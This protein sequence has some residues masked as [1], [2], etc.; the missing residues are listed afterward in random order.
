MRELARLLVADPK[1]SHTMVD[2]HLLVLAP[3]CDGLG[4]EFAPRGPVSSRADALCSIT[5]EALRRIGASPDCPPDCAPDPSD[6]V[7]A[8]LVER[9]RRLLTAAGHA[10]HWVDEPAALV[11]PLWVA[12]FGT[13]PF[14]VM[15]GA[16]V[17]TSGTPEALAIWERTTRITVAGLR[18]LRV[19]VVAL[20]TS[21]APDPALGSQR[22][23][24][25]VLASLVGDHESFEPPDLGPESPW[26]TAVLG[27]RRDLSQVWRGL[28]WA[29]AR[30]AD[31][32]VEEDHEDQ[33]PFYPPSATADTADYHRWLRSR[34]EATARPLHGGLPAR[35]G[36]AGASRT[37]QFSVVVPVY[38]PPPWA[39]DRCVASVLAQSCGDFQLVL[40]DDAS[41][42]RTLGDQLRGYCTLDP[43]VEVV[44]LEHNGGIS[45]ATN[46]AIARARGEFLVFLDND[47][48][49][50]PAALEKMAAA[51]A[52]RPD[53]DVLYSDEDKLDAHGVRCTPTLKPAWSPDLLLSCAYLCHLLVVRRSLTDALGGLRTEFDGSQ[54]HDLML[55]A[56]EQARA[57]VHVP[58][59]LYHWRV[60]AGSASGDTGAKPWAYA[61]SRRA[62][63]DALER[64]GIVADVEPHERYAGNFHVRRSVIGTPKVSVIVPFRDEPGL[65]AACYRSIVATAG[66]DNFELLLVDNDSELPETKALLSDLGRDE[67][68]RVLPS[69]GRFDWAAINNQAASQADGELLCF[70]NNDIEARSAGWLAAMA[71]H[72]QRTEVG[73]VGALLRYPDETIQHAGVVIGM[74]WGAAHVQQDLPIGRPSYLLLA[75]VTRN[76]SAVT[77]ACMMTRRSVF[78]ALGGFDTR[79]PVA[80]NDIDYCLRL[81]E[82]GMTVVYTPLAELTH[83]ES[84]SRGHAD[85]VVEVP[86]FLGRW[87]DAILAGDPY[88]NPNLTRFDPYCRLST[89]EDRYQW[90]IFRSMLEKLS[91]T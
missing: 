14:E 19:R 7:L 24:A 73:A 38:R 32:L 45:A 25:C 65:T 53:A 41:G 74:N 57:V 12:A 91:T 13:A 15:I 50:H 3:S 20:P 80:F 6:P 64:R 84:K 89:E 39:L 87:K 86:H 79:L 63:E 56:T 42:D 43:R 27:A 22:E 62:I 33:P 4:A 35:R 85:D 77:G 30:L 54:D 40:A 78:E 1:L 72:A 47:D 83:F 8:S 11:L 5:R 81:H 68:V 76:C 17:P 55:R 10:S 34:G 61:A 71:G 37:P 70:L 48:E 49:L 21:V 67:R 52:A 29:T 18:G 66:Y 44:S 36:R 9:A 31:R 60:L 69:P 2:T 75:E 59:I 51:I 90:S 46:G 58:E 23:L 28:D 16:G 88:H 82:A 26:V